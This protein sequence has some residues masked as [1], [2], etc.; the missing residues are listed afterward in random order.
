[1]AKHALCIGIN[2]YPGTDS[3]LAGCV[4]DAN[5]WARELARRRFN[6]EKL[7]DGQA[8]GKAM[9]SAIRGTVARATAGD[10]VVV[11]YS[12]HGSFV[13][14]DDGDEPD[15]TDECLCPHDVRTKGPIT[16]DELFELYSA[17]PPGVRILM[18]SDSCHSGTVA[19][20]APVTTP[21][22][23]KGGHAPQRKVRFLPPAV[24]LP[25]REA[26]KLGV[27]RCLRRSS[28]PGRYASLLMAGCQDTEYSYDAYFEGRP[29]GA[30]SFVALRALANLPAA[31]TY[32]QWFA[33]IRE[34]LPS[35]QYPQTPNL[36][37]SK[38]MKQWQVLAQAAA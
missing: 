6:V 4:N 20:F 38:S 8:T 21:P 19:R 11:Q 29:N 2:N 16:D 25:R 34:A 24:Y 31:A 33:L 32:A 18:I 26:A 7:L 30:F 17:R 10:L 3:D 12:G 1:M 9:R 15:G 13:P 14:D 23:M 27:R 5:D 28:P 35:Q 37:G 36:Y 22:T